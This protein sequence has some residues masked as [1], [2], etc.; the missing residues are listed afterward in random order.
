MI[1]HVIS[2]GQLCEVGTYLLSSFINKGTE[3]QRSL[4]AKGDKTGIWQSQAS[5][6]SWNIFQSVI[7]GLPALRITC[8]IFRTTD[9]KV[10]PPLTH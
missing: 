5:L 8:S 9:F 6:E 4:P 2:I 3:A 7:L 10:L 1:F